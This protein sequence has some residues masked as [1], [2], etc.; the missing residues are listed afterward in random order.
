MDTSANTAREIGGQHEAGLQLFEPVRVVSTL[1]AMWLVALTVAS[2]LSNSQVVT[3]LILLAG[4]GPALAQGLLLPA[5]TRG[6]AAGLWFLWTFVIVFLVSDLINNASWTDYANVFNVVFVFSIGFIVACC[7][8]RLLIRRIVAIYAVLLVPYLIHVNMFGNYVFGRL[9]AGAQPNLWGLISLNVALGA[10]CVRNRVLAAA[11]WAV[12]LVTLYHAQARGS[13]VALVPIVAIGAYAWWRYSQGTDFSWKV[14]AALLALIAGM[15]VVLVASDFFINDVM[16]LNDPYRGLQ[17]GLTGRDVAWAK[18]LQI[19]YD[20]PLLGVG[21]RRHEM[22]LLGDQAT[23]SHNAYIAML[24]DTGFAGFTVYVLFLAGSLVAALRLG[25]DPRLRLFLVAVILSYS[26]VGIFERRAINAGN[27]FSVTFIFACL[28]AMRLARVPGV[29]SVVVAAAPS[30]TI[31]AVQQEQKPEPKTEPEPKPKPEPAETVAFPVAAV[32]RQRVTNVHE[33]RTVVES[34]LDVDAVARASL[35]RYARAL[36]DRQWREYRRL[37]RDMFVF[38]YAAHFSGYSM[39]S[40]Y[41]DRVVANDDGTAVVRTQF[42]HRAN[43]QPLL[44]DWRIGAGDFDGFKVLDVVIDDVSLA[45]TLRADFAAIV[46]NGGF[47]RLLTTL[48]RQI[49]DL[50]GA[51]A[52]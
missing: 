15:V 36:T 35:G 52:A 29:A 25:G 9:N 1:Y 17:S 5:D 21:F 14:L 43:E 42:A 47:S 7:E 30:A 34:F 11:C 31:T 33:I 46:A 37:M 49:D 44:L 6:T 16:R 4:A 50:K 23:S 10:Y 51:A 13:M 2:H 8:D 12:A 22:F 45:G 24:A 26:F 41:V 28:L 32:G 38:G 27:S 48:R 39:D 20:A 19:W 18:A 40:L 3:E